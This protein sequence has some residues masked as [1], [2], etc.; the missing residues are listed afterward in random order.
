MNDGTATQVEEIL[1]DSPIA[2]ASTL[3]LTNMGE[4]VFYGDPFTQFGSSFWRY[5]TLS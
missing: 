2:G 1:A 3:P 5:L 4:G